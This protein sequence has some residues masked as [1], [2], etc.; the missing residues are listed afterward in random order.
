M[1]ATLLP[2]ARAEA[3]FVSSLP[4]GSTP[5]GAEV[6]DAIRYEIRAHHGTRGCACQVAQ[7]FG[8]HP[9]AAVARMRWALDTVAATYPRRAD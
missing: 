6:A 7:E 4:T 3:V 9:D 5:T 2:A 8:D 1:S